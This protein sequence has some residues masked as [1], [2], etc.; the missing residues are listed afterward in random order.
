MKTMMSFS[1]RRAVDNHGEKFFTV[2][3]PGFPEGREVVYHPNQGGELA[4]GQV[5]YRIP[6]ADT[7][8]SLVQ[9]LA[10]QQ[11]AFSGELTIVEGVKIKDAITA[12]RSGLDEYS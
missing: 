8:T 4:M 9:L 5:A 12:V 6:D 2:E 10:S 1:V 3:S 7:S 11:F